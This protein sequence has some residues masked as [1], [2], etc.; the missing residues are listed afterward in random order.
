MLLF[1]KKDGLHR[2]WSP[3]LFTATSLISRTLLGTKRPRVNACWIS[4]SNCCEEIYKHQE[5]W[6]CSWWTELWNDWSKGSFSF[7]HSTC[8]MSRVSSCTVFKTNFSLSFLTLWFVSTCAVPHDIHDLTF[9]LSLANSLKQHHTSWGDMT[10]PRVAGIWEIWTQNS[11]L[12]NYMF[13]AP[14]D[15]QSCALELVVQRFTCHL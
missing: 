14:W 2:I 6:L 13:P 8:Q 4:A 15:V 5:K 11:H 1:P 10:S 7:A 9:R 12:S 3:V